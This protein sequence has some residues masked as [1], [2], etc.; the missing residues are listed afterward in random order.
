MAVLRVPIDA[1]VNKDLRRLI[2]DEGIE[3]FCLREV[4]ML[5]L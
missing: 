2:V 5:R 3:V 4:I 1:I